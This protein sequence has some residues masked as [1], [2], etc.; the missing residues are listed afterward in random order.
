MSGFDSL[1]LA[2]EGW[3]DKPL[4]DLPDALR[5]RIEKDFL[6]MPWDRLTAAGRRDVTQQIDYH[7]DPAME[8]VRQ[9]WCG[10]AERKHSI[11]TQ[12]TEWE[13]VATPTALDLAQKE[14][15]LE[16]L[17]QELAGIETEVFE[18]SGQTDA[19]RNPAQPSKRKT[20]S[21]RLPAPAVTTP[22]EKPQGSTVRREAGKLRTKD[23]HKLWQKA[24]EAAK[25]ARPNMTVSWHAKQI[26]KTPIAK[27]RSAET[28]RR[29]L[30]S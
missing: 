27:N 21:E 30:K 24:Y 12:I 19:P 17:R 26:A 3:F 15:R 5:Q 11:M 6:P 1:T 4:C 16:E 20:D 22:A 7:D 18:E 8:P 10:W 2:C 14:A 13:A 25:K 23:T 9:F 29:V 28:I